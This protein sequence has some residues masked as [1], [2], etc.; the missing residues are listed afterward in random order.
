MQDGVHSG[1]VDHDFPQGSA[2]G[3]SATQVG[4]RTGTQ[5]WTS[6]MEAE[7]GAKS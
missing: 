3:G 5:K 1:F 4:N 7:S 2:T 6:R